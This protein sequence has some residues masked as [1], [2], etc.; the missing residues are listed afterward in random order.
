MSDTSG[1]YWTKEDI[2]RFEERRKRRQ[3]A[4]SQPPLPPGWP[5]DYDP[6]TEL[7]GCCDPP[8]EPEKRP[9]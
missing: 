6:R 1:P 4:K 8:P 7:Y 5:I 9:A 3:K 2:K